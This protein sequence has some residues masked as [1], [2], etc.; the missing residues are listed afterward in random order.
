MTA[1]HA[2]VRQKPIGELFGGLKP[3]PNCGEY[4]THTKPAVR[5]SRIVFRKMRLLLQKTAHF[6][7]IMFKALK[8]LVKA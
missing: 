5:L 8:L 1:K 6:I 4:L 3:R 2:S 7:H